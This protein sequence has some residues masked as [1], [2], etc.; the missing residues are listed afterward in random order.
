VA[1]AAFLSVSGWRAIVH[2]VE[3]KVFAQIGEEGATVDS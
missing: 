3:E 2:L 1:V